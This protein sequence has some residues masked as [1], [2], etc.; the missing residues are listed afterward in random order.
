MS[1]G[2]E[3]SILGRRL[4]TRVQGFIDRL[5]E[6]GLRTGVAAGVDLSRALHALP[7]LDRSAFREACRAT[8][9]KSPS[10]LVA[11]DRVFEEYFG[12]RGLP[13]TP[14]SEEGK[15]PHGRERSGRIPAGPRA[16]GPKEDDL[17]EELQGRYSPVAPP[18]AV[19]RTPIPSERLRRHRAGAR[20]F[21]RSV[22]T[23]P[24]RRWRAHPVG[25]V[26]LRR[27]ARASLRSGGEFLELARRNRAP[28]RADLVVLWD[29]SGSMREHTTNLFGLVYALH[30]AVRRTRVF[31]F[32]HDLVEVTGLLAGRSYQRALPLLSDRLR[33]TGGGTQIAHCLSE[34]RRHHGSE[35]R[36]SSTLVIVSDGWDLG[37]PRELADELR[38]LRGQAHQVVWVNP[39]AAQTGFRPV[40]AAL[41]A[42]SPYVDLLTSPDDFPRPHG[43]WRQVGVPT[44]NRP[45]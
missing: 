36:G 45:L 41:R 11:V 40:T 14:P 12:T 28:R 18:L 31:A 39:Y 5:R 9:A 26:D 32:G 37:A 22:A 15:L 20:R 25:T 35:L 6:E 2:P 21:R 27:T 7:L 1:S 38:R 16:P 30:R 42:A 29:V 43:P 4:A 17:E 3:P 34:F 8:L 33:S 24:G 13:L 23:L 44:L 10:D 19:V